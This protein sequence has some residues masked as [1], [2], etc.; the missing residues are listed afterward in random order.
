[1][2]R[3]PNTALPAANSAGVRLLFDLTPRAPVWRAGRSLED[4]A[5]SARALRELMHVAFVC[6]LPARQC[7]R[8]PRSAGKTIKLVVFLRSYGFN[9]S[10]GGCVHWFCGLQSCVDH[11]PVSCSVSSL[12]SL[13][14]ERL[15][16]SCRPCRRWCQRAAHF[17][18]ADTAAPKPA[19]GKRVEPCGVNVVDVVGAPTPAACASQHR[20]HE[21]IVV[22]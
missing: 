6:H 19:L 7:P 12:S 17:L 2:K 18:A 4:C 9:L 3:R 11:C 20:P 8:S 15:R 22:Q 1:M 10:H 5:S 21:R 13:S 14:L 16:T